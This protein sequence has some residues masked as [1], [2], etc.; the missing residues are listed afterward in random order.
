[1]PLKWYGYIHI[2][3]TLHVKR[4]F[5]DLGD[6]IE[7]RSSDFVEYVFKPFEAPT[8]KHA[9]AILKQKIAAMK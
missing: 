2:N 5:G 4:F 9:I 1:M 3:G 7:A 8:R 6:V